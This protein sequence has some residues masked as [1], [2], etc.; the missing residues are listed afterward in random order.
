[1]YITEF[2]I[3]WLGKRDFAEQ[4]FARFPRLAAAL[5]LPRASPCRNSQPAP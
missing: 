2:S 3:G 1:M 4:E 5:L